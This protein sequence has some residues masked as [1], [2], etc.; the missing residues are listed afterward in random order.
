MLSAPSYGTPGRSQYGRVYIVNTNKDGSL[1]LDALDLDTQSQAILDG[2]I[3][4][5]KFGT[6]LA[7]VDLNKDGVDDLAVSAPSTGRMFFPALPR[8]LLLLS[9]V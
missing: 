2:F 1:P 3:E 9:S 5:G 8:F 4:N 6:G 7:V